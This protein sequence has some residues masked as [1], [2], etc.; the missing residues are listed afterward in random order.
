MSNNSAAERR[1]AKNSLFL[2]G[3]EELVT[4]FAKSDSGLK[5]DDVVILFKENFNRSMQANIDYHLQLAEL[6]KREGNEAM[7]AL[8]EL[9]AKI[10][11]SITTT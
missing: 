1:S 9:Q 7:S 4:E 10:Y 6:H 8:H 3:L 2:Q 11:R 5:P